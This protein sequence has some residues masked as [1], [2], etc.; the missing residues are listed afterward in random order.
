MAMRERVGRAVSKVST[1]NPFFIEKTAG[2]SIPKRSTGHL[3]W[4]RCPAVWEWHPAQ[5]LHQ[6]QREIMQK[7]NFLC[8]DHPWTSALKETQIKTITQMSQMWKEHRIENYKTFLKWTPR[9]SYV[10]LYLQHPLKQIKGRKHHGEIKTSQ[11]I[12]FPFRNPISWYLRR[13][14]VHTFFLYTFNLTLI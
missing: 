4:D 13:S 6:N 2:K 9:F 14:E 7:T 5:Q 11:V 3:H 8:Q 10:W 12:Q 1:G